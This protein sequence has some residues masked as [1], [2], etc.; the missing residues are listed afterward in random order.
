MNDNNNNV[1]KLSASFQIDN[2]N[3]D[4]DKFKDK[5]IDMIID[6]AEENG[7]EVVLGF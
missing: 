3:I 7:V 1:Y 2:P 5:L 6:H 4:I